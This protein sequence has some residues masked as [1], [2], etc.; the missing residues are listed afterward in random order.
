[1]TLPALRSSRPDSIVVVRWLAPLLQMAALTPDIIPLDR[2]PAGLPAAALELRRR[3]PARGLLF[4]PSFSSALLFRLAGIPA[5]RGSGTDHREFMLHDVVPREQLDAGHRI[6]GYLLLAGV[7]APAEPPAPSIDV[8]DSEA[9]RW[10]RLMGASAVP[11]IGVF[12][13]SHASSRRWAPDR[14]AVVVRAL[15]NEGMR[16]VVF[17]SSAEKELTR[18]VAGSQAFDAGGRTDLP[19]LAAGL[20]ACDILVTN[21]SGP[22]HLAMAVGTP[23]LSLWGAGNPAST[24]PTG[25]RHRVLRRPELAC[26]PC[27][28]NT[29]PRSGAGFILPSAR[30]ECLNLITPAEVLS[31]V[32][33]MLDGR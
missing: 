23:T 7:G 28:K 19:L 4:T 15:A 9:S 11:T 31:A 18:Q 32:H 24:G 29:C 5:V 33:S 1:M 3:R 30:N 17:G 13:G 14:F 2:G 10:Q 26:V 21:D 16:V 20:A 12:P 22:M 8:P 6:A 27:V 25:S